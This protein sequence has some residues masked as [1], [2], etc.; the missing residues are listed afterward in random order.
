[1][2]TPTGIH[3]VGRP[4]DAEEAGERAAQAAVLGD[5]L[6]LR[7]LSAIAAGA[8]AAQLPE[9]LHVAAERA[10]TAI[11]ALRAA[12][13]IHHE[14]DTGW[15]LTARAWVRFGRLLA[16]APPQGIP[17]PP[18]ASLTALPVAVESVARDLAYRFS[19]T[20]SAETV[21]RYMAESY[22]LLSQRAQVRTHL[23]ALTAR[24][25][26]ERLSALASA[27]GLVLRGTPEVLFVCVQNA[28]R[29]QLAAA[30]LRHLAGDA[31]HVRTAGSEPAAEVH[32]RIAESLAEVGVPATDDY[33]KPLT[34]EVVQAADYVV[35]MGCGD[36]CPVYP[37]R[38]YL[39]W[40]LDDPLTLDEPGLRRVRDEIRGRVEGLLVDLGFADH[41]ASR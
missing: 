20:F 41:D 13:I 11:E 30:Y 21:S 16:A 12:G 31:V 9:I 15:T 14:P 6:N 27:K 24:Y 22:L 3:R 26:A 18:P 7:V 8:P 28:G 2:T 25:A 19:S 23:A 29:S 38:R 39:D 17:L 36:A 5:T 40:D 10:E 4:L 34:D 37:G 33:P 35:T 1:M 32:P